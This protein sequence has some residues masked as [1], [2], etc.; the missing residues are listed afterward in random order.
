MVYQ[1]NYIKGVVVLKSSTLKTIIVIILILGIIGS[2][3]SGFSL[4]SIVDEF[5]VTLFISG[6]IGTGLYCFPLFAIAGILENQEAIMREQYN[7][8][9]KKLSSS[10]NPVA[11]SNSRLNLSAVASGNN[12]AST[13]TCPDCGETNPRNTRVCKSCGR[14]K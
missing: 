14:E 1:L 4:K 9:Q 13:W 7:Q 8:N 6:I 2:I 12:S 11:T 5:N 10:A 3:I